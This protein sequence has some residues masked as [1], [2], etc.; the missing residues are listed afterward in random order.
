M[1]PQVGCTFW[2]RIFHFLYNETG[3]RRVKSPFEINRFDVHFQPKK[4]V[5]V[6]HYSDNLWQWKEKK[7]I[8]STDKVRVPIPSLVDQ[9]LPFNSARNDYAMGKGTT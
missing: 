2:K 4:K 6:L 7:L 5:Q 9:P 1:I 3:G 8:D